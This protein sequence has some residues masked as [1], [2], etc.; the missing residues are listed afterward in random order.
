MPQVGKKFSRAGQSVGLEALYFTTQ[1]GEG[2]GFVMIAGC[3]H[4][5][6]HVAHS[7]A[8]ASSDKGIVIPCV[9]LGKSL[10][11]C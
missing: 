7:D 3:A 4:C 6:Q 9:A 5:T 1:K 10:N 2:C 11:L 8:K